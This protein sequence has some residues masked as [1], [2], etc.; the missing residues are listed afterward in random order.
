MNGMYAKYYPSMAFSCQC[1]YCTTLT[2]N[3]YVETKPNPF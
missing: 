3:F 1:H 2:R